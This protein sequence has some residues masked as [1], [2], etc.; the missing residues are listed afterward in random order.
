MSLDRQA[1]SLALVGFV[2]ACG[3]N[4]P[5]GPAGPSDVRDCEPDDGLPPGRVAIAMEDR[6][7]EERNVYVFATAELP[8][9]PIRLNREPMSSIP[10]QRMLWSPDGTMLAYDTTSGIELVD[11]TG[12]IPSEPR[13]L[14]TMNDPTG[15]STV[16][17]LHSWSPDSRWVAFIARGATRAIFVAEV[18]DGMPNVAV[19]FTSGSGTLWPQV[20]EWHPSGGGFV[21]TDGVGP[22]GGALHWVAV[23]PGGLAA[24]EGM[25]LFPEHCAFSPAGDHIACSAVASG[26]HV[27][28]FNG[29]APGAPRQVYPDDADD[30][31]YRYP[32][33][34]PDGNYLSWWTWR[35]EQ[36]FVVDVN[37]DAPA[38][39]LNDI[40]LEG[41]RLDVWDF[42]WVNSQRIYFIVSDP[43]QV[44]GGL[45]VRDLGDGALGPSQNLAP[46]ATPRVVVAPD[47][48]L[49]VF[50]DEARIHDGHFLVS[51][52]DGAGPQP[53]VNVP[54]GGAMQ[55]TPSGTHL[56]HSRDPDP[57]YSA[58]ELEL[59][60][61]SPPDADA[62]PALLRKSYG[63]WF[64]GMLISQDDQLI[65]WEDEPDR[66][67]RFWHL[68]L[69]GQP[70]LQLQEAIEGLPFAA[71][72]DSA[73][74][75]PIP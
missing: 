67:A 44:K 62:E 24:P 63:L 26:V 5:A 36:T 68:D 33:W 17:R 69:A 29:D 46:A 42:D 45:Y 31:D 61:I 37:D 56:L 38:I 25:G 19:R 52:G 27:I 14:T 34:S 4:L 35:L 59:F 60:V 54:T 22:R 70:P 41:E 48:Q 51:L 20:L 2:V 39:P 55:F 74:W 72:V 64:S 50:F 43:D 6:P 53:L 9:C 18:I 1:V 11:L 8:A 73:A 30:S 58:G 3:D 21:F 15:D 7:L 49:A 23:S 10:V 47:H 65:L 66:P 71:A 40:G 32:K 75:A 57:S 13:P 12:P 16:L 28:E